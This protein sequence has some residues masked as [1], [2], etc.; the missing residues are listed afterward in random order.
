MAVEGRRATGE[1]E[2][3]RAAPVFVN[4]LRRLLRKIGAQVIRLHD[5]SRYPRRCFDLRRAFDLDADQSSLVVT[6]SPGEAK[7][8]NSLRSGQ[9]VVGPASALLVRRVQERGHRI[10]LK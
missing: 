3:S 7:I 8:R 6:V 5:G 1:A 4:G 9:S 10:P 2:G